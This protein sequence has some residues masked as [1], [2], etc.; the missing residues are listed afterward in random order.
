MYPLLSSQAALL[1]IACPLGD[2]MPQ[3]TIPIIVHYRRHRS[4]DR[5]LLSVRPKTGDLR[6][7]RAEIVAN[8]QSVVGKSNAWQK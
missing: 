6:I 8:E 3:L 4:I 2:R 7:P 1:I 5:Q